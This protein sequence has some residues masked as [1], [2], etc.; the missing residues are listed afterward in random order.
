MGSKELNVKNFYN[1]FI[2]SIKNGTVKYPD[3]NYNPWK[4][5]KARYHNRYTAYINNDLMPKCFKQFSDGC[6]N[7]YYRLDVSGWKQFK[8]E[9]E[10]I[11]KKVNMNPYLWDLQ[12]AFEH[13]N[14]KKDWFDEVIKLLYVNCKLKV[15]VGYNDYKNRDNH[16]Y[17]D[18]NKL[19]ALCEI[20]KKLPRI[21]EL[22]SDENGENNTLLVIIGNCGSGYEELDCKEYFGYRGY[23]IYLEGI[24]VKHKRLDNEN[25]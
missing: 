18:E 12:I 5:S 9:A 2:E 3:K 15:V 14:K 8:Q 6:S 23:Q 7:E 20:L 25:R 13:E 24:D 16:D 19:D 22:L 4:E 17:S 21:N 1:T 10:D 11:C